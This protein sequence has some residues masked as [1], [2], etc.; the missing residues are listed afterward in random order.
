MRIPVL[1]PRD[2][3]AVLLGALFLLPAAGWF[4]IARP[5]VRSLDQASARLS[6]ERELL[7]REEA[8]IAQAVTFP[9][10]WEQGSERLVEVAPRLFVGDNPAVA[11]AELAHYLQAGAQS[12]RVLLTQIEPGTP[13]EAGTGLIAVPLH[14]EGETDL[15]GLLSMLHGL[16]AGVRLVRVEDLTVQGLRTTAAISPEEPQVLSFSFRATGFALSGVEEAVSEPN[17]E[18]VLP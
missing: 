8:L 14:V 17:V 16:E 18:G 12:S 1:S 15:E 6:T 5:F 7:S 3:R 4:W 10:A 13:E 9:A 11:S 2:R